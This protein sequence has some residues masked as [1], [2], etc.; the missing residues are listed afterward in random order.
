MKE[1]G[2][3][4]RIPPKEF[5]DRKMRHRWGIV[6]AVISAFAIMIGLGIS[7]GS[8]QVLA[9]QS[10]PNGEELQLVAKPRLCGLLGIE[11]VEYKY[12]KDGRKLGGSVTDLCGSWSEVEERYSN[13]NSMIRTPLP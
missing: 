2:D 11:I 5:K 8:S 3:S 9:T 12:S 10:L 1:T 4:V 13:S 6:L 7:Y